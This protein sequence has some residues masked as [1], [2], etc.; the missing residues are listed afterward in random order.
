MG[1][2]GKKDKDKSLKQ[3]I[4]RR[5]QTAKSNLRSNRKRVLETKAA[6]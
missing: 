2:K 4:K 1:D 3:K 5:E 6:T